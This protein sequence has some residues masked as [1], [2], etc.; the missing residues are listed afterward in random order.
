MPFLSVQKWEVTD[1]KQWRMFSVLLKC[2]PVPRRQLQEV[3]LVLGQETAGTVSMSGVS[4]VS[5]K[6]SEV[7]VRAVD[8]LN[9]A[10]TLARP[11]VFTRSH[12]AGRRRGR[13]GRVAETGCQE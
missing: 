6:G 4:T 9:M 3:S 2:S 1:P 11:A 7:V 8:C 10:N 5:S 13:R 12:Q